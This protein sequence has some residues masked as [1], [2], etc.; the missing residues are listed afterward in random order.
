MRSF[1]TIMLRSW[2]VMKKT[3]FMVMLVIPLYAQGDIYAVFVGISEY[4]EPGNN[5]TYCHRDAIEMYEMLKVHTTHNKILL[6]I[7]EQAKHNNIVYYTK[8]LFQRAQ[9]DDIVI[10]YFSGHGSRNVFFT[11]NKALTFSTLKSI[12]KQCKAKRKFIFADACF[13]GALRQ[14]GNQTAPVNS[15]IG[16]NVLL[17]LSA[18]SDQY[19]R[20]NSLLGN[21]I[22]TYFLLA[23]L[24]GGADINDDHVITA[25]E[26]FDFVHPKVK[27]KTNGDQVPVM[28]GHFDENMIILKVNK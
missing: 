18:R 28:W 16:N 26:L 7:N 2:T 17:F 9:P 12:F 6:L 13:A 24:K 25:R 20:E 4:E 21:G 27:E 8:Q 19:A 14:T 5:L 22:F 23:G 3:L 1:I 10:F 15:N 11:Y